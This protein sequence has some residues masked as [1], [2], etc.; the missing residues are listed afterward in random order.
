[1]YIQ[2]TFRQKW[3]DPRLTYTAAPNQPG[4]LTIMS[5]EAKRS[6]W[7]PDTEFYNAIDVR[8]ARARYQ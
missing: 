5:E 1:M 4:F 6:L 7:M 3:N 2:V 8:Y